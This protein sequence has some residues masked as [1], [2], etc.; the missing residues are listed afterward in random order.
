MRILGKTIGTL[1]ASI[2]I[3]MLAACAGGDGGFAGFSGPKAPRST[4]LAGLKMK[5]EGPAGFCVDRTT[6]T[7]TLNAGFV[8]LGA[9]AAISN[10]ARDVMPPIR[11][12]LTASVSQVAD[13]SLATPDHLARFLRSSAGQATLA[14]SG[15]AAH[16]RILETKTVEGALLVQVR[17]ASPNRANVLADKYWRA[18]FTVNGHLVSLT[19]T[20]LHTHPFADR[21]GRRLL[22]E[23]IAQMRQANPVSNPNGTGIFAGFQNLASQ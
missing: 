14:Q 9:C 2:L 13:A 12:V 19:V 20:A 11:A 23:F 1:T 17:D 8:V 16:I 5:I 10:N 22:R 7:S 4:R 6:K 3:L 21:T 15:S 18:I